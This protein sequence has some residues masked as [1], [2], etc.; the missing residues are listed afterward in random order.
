MITSNDRAEEKASQRG[1]QVGRMSAA[2]PRNQDKDRFSGGEGWTEDVLM[3]G[4]SLNLMSNGL[5]DETIAEDSFT[6][7]TLVV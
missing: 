1:E 5:K 2:V 6:N 4:G 7:T 3:R